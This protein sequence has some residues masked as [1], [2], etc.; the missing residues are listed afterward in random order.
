MKTIGKK[1]ADL[2]YLNNNGKPF[3]Q[4]TIKN[5]LINPKYKGYYCGNK[6]RTVDYHTKERIKINESEWKIYGE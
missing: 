4:G 5:I 6:T 3:T 2:G 1:L